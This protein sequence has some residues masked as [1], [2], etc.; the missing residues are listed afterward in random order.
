MVAV[1]AR[2]N[3]RKVAESILRR[4]GSRG[5]FFA[6]RAWYV[7][8][9]S[10]AKRQLARGKKASCPI[11]TYQDLLHHHEIPYLRTVFILIVRCY[12]ANAPTS[13]GSRL[14]LCALA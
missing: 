11:M 4:R 10:W 5:G 1:P 9:I 2:T 6:R 3:S 7:D 8:I 13:A 14:S 12:A